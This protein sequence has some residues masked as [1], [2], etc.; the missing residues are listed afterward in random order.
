MSFELYFFRP[1]FAPLSDDIINAYLDAKIPLPPGQTPQDGA[2]HYGNIHTGVYFSLYRNHASEKMHQDYIGFSDTGIMMELNYV[3]PDFFGREAFIFVKQMTDEL[4]LY[5]ND[6]R[7]IID[8]P[9]PCNSTLLFE[10][11]QQMNRKASLHF[12]DVH[13]T[14]YLAPELSDKLWGFNVTRP[15]LQAELGNAYYVPQIMLFK[16]LHTHEPIRLAAW[17]A[18]NAAVFPQVDYVIV[19][20]RIKNWLGAVKEETGII[21]YDQLIM[22]LGDFLTRV[23]GTD[24]YVLLPQYAQDVA[25]LIEK[26][27]LD[28]AFNT[29]MVL[30]NMSQV[31]N[32]KPL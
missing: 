19:N 21:P 14:T 11:W 2:W 23:N 32:Y 6:P 18:P 30:A 5:I 17:L 10:G 4:G 3:R 29:R 16:D 8:Y 26:I 9:V 28:T 27:P 24:A 31:S 1:K 12:F 22:I 15:L 7:G 25:R 13:A 20:R